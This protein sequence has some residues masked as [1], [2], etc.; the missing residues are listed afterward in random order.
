MQIYLTNLTQYNNEFLVGEW[1]ELVCTQKEHQD[2]LSRVL[3]RDEECF[4]TDTDGI[5]FDVGEH[6]DIYGLNEKLEEYELLDDQGQ[7]CVAFLLS[8]GY[9]WAYSMENRE[10]VILY[11]GESPEDVAY[12]L[13]E[14]GCF[15]EIPES[16]S[17]Y[18][19]YEAI[20][21]DIGHDGY[22]QTDEGVFC[23]TG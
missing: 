7:L 18:V 15:G 6:D 21:R 17:N 5:P 3:G 16:L 12:S 1:L 11:A 20:A 23:Y 8:E 13:V 14:N 9:D 10:D 4:I 2:S 19:D 22:V